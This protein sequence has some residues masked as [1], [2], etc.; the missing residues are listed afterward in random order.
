MEDRHVWFRSRRRVIWAL[1]HRAG[2]PSAPRILDAGCGT[3]RN[4]MEFQTLG[5]AEGV[6]VSPDAI[7]FCRRRGLYGVRQGSIEELPYEDG[8]FDLLFATDVIEH[9]PDEGSAL[10]ELR[11]VAAPGASLIITVPA[12][13]WLWSRHDESWHHYRRYTRK[14]LRER[15][16]AQGWE[17]VVTTYFYSTLLAPVAVVRTLQRLHSNGNGK[18]DLHRSLGALDRWLELP[19]RGE[20]KLIERGASLPAGV[21]LG[22]VCRSSP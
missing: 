1:I 14:L 2:P 20:A 21:S 11:R 4:L 9:L 5:P 6:D 3:G 15:V 13:S 16:S 19:L 10:T 22:M 8:R 7:E 17:P 12:Y 18:S